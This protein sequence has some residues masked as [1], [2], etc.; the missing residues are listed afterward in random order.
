[1]VTSFWLSPCNHGAVKQVGHVPQNG[2]TTQ[3]RL[4]D[5][6]YKA[7]PDL[8]NYNSVDVR[9]HHHPNPHYLFS[10]PKL[11]TGSR[12]P[13]ALWPSQSQAS[14]CPRL[15]AA[16]PTAQRIRRVSLGLASGARERASSETAEG[17]ADKRLD[18]HRLVSVPPRPG[19]PGPGYR[20]RH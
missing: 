20:H 5:Q 12:A 19:S 9:P 11:V 10:A 3:S 16:E 2:R 6:I 4:A 8:R 13:L 14:R 1:M 7:S 18:P 17:K 15:Y